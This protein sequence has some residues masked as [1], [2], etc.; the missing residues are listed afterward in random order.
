MSEDGRVGGKDKIREG[1]FIELLHICMY[2]QRF[3]R[4]A[5]AGEC[6]AAAGFMLLVFISSVASQVQW[7]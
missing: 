7:L 4:T 3:S 1:S 2:I 5:M 6:T